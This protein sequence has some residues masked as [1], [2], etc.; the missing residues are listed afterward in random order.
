MNMNSPVN[1]HFPR[2]ALADIALMCFDPGPAHALVIY[3]KRRMGKTEFLRYDLKP[4][5]EAQG[6]GVMY[7]SFM[8][9]DSRPGVMVDPLKA[10]VHELVKFAMTPL[11]KIAQAAGRVARALPIKKVA[12]A[13]A[14][15]SKSPRARTT[16]L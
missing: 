11:D 12:I 9:E 13:A 14:V 1:W 15:K 6:W 5:A 8:L 7:Y 10:F 4:R 3:D 16:R 2:T